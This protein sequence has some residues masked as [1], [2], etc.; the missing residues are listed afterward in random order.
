MGKVRRKCGILNGIDIDSN[1]RSGGLS[2]GW[3]NDCKVSLR[4][5]SNRHIDVMIDEDSEGRTWRCTGF[6]GAPE[7]NLREVS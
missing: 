4:S 5:F 2:L 7:E 3:N 6:Y 1:G